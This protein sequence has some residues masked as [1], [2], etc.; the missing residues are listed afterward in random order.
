VC[1]CAAAR[2][3]ARLATSLIKAAAL[4]LSHAGF[5][6]V[7]VDVTE[8]FG[9]EPE[10]PSAGADTRAPT[11]KARTVLDTMTQQ[12][13]VS[14]AAGTLRCLRTELR[15]C[16]DLPRLLEGAAL[17]AQL[18]GVPDTAEGALQVVLVLLVNRFPRVRR[19]TAEQLYV[20]LLAAQ[21]SSEEGTSVL[22]AESL[23]AAMDCLLLSPWDGSLDDARTARDALASTLGVE[24]RSR[25]VQRTTPAPATA[26]TRLASC[27]PAVES[28]A[29][30][31]EDA[32]RGGGY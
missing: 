29:S 12:Q 7:L 30:L 22:P 9:D 15:G 13:C 10:Q 5:A 28:Y 3:S 6:P 31:L 16:S 1:L 4:L 27:R 25:R 17:A 32:A 11:P 26:G 21:C 18:V 24:V 8:L 2:R 19:A 23:D 14:F 20:A